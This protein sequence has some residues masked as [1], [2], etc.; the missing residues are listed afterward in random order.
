MPVLTLAYR[1]CDRMLPRYIKHSEVEGIAM[2]ARQ[3]LVDANTEAISLSVLRDIGGLK[4]NGIQFEL[5]VD[6]D[7]A[8]N[9]EHGNPVLG[10][11]EFD[12]AASLDATVLSVS[13]VSETASEELVLSTFAHELGHAIFDAPSWIAAAAKGPGLFDDPTELAR[14]AYR[15]TTRDAEHLAKPPVALELAPRTA[16]NSELDR[17]IHFAELRAN[18]FMGSLLVPRQQLCRAVEELAPKHGVTIHRSASLDPEVPGTTLRLTA[19]GD[20]G[21]FDM[22]CLQKALAKRFGV[23]RRFI[24]VRMERYGLLASGAGIA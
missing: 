10:V 12:P 21:F 9:D 17:S 4:I 6:T 24:Q 8:V 23:H 14:K 16:R 19:D 15:T 7:H 3:Q 2:L 5:W 13:P 18:E 11:C 20:I 1:C 22:E